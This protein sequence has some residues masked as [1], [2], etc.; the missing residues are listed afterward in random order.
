M[1]RRVCEDKP[2]LQQSRPVIGHPRRW[3]SVY[4]LSV[5]VKWYL[6]SRHL[7]PFL[8]V[9]VLS[10]AALF[11]PGLAYGLSTRCDCASP[12]YVP[13]ET[14]IALIWQVVRYIE[15]QWSLEE[16]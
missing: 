10:F 15:I 5:C 4:D 1:T 7:F 8:N 13:S 11:S 14:V 12:T 16:L 2:L 6:G 3:D 9:A